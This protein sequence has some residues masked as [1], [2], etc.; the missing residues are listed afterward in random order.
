GASAAV[1]SLRAVPAPS[2]DSS[3]MTAAVRLT[4]L[5]R[6]FGDVAALD[7]LS[8]SAPAGLVTAVLGPNGAGKTTAIEC[9]VGLGRPDSG[10]VRVLRTD[11]WQVGADPRA[12]VRVLLQDT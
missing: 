10:T 7:G 8:W 11:P 1:T 4:D 5:H 3:A 9:A 12:P 2:L 6:S